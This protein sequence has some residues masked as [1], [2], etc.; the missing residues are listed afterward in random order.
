MTHCAPLLYI[1]N[2]S[3][4]HLCLLHFAPSCSA[5]F[6]LSLLLISSTSHSHLSCIML[7]HTC[8][9]SHD[10]HT[11]FHHINNHRNSNSTRTYLI[12][13]A[14]LS[15]GSCHSTMHHSACATHLHPHYILSHYALQ[16]FQHSQQLQ[17]TRTTLH[18]SHVTI[19]LPA[20]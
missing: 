13:I 6:I 2:E 9:M 20:Y 8:A 11:H 3:H 14:S 4:T 17:L 19:P 15:G 12:A 5:T 7:R 10:T 16:H 18:T 1:S